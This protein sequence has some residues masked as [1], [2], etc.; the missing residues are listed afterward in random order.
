MILTDDNFGTLVNAIELG[1]TVYDKIVAY[2]RFQMSQLI[3]LV[4][5]FVTATVFN[6]NDGVALTP[7]MVL[8][9]AFF[10]VIFGVIV[11]AV[12]PS[13]PDLMRRPPRDPKVPVSNRP[14]V[15]RWLFY[16][17]VRFL[18]ALVPLLFGPDP[19][20]VKHPSA[21]M[22]MAFVVMCLSTTFSALVLRRD[23]TSGLVAPVLKA[24]AILSI[25][26]ALVI[27]S[28][29]L[30]SLQRGLLTQSLT[31]PQ[32]LAC[33]GLALVAPVVIELDKLVRRYRL[34]TTTAYDVPGAVAPRR[35]LTIAA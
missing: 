21:S 1:R 32:W 12:D 23:P 34:R 8:F 24:M 11:I 22:T 14:A 15:G 19:L 27:L 6:I 35:Q 13:D 26:V 20:Q 18:T 17:G 28:T 2:V 10:V 7:L 5:L 31:G 3:S 29:E 9:V 25:P 16:G 4:L 30:T 33:L